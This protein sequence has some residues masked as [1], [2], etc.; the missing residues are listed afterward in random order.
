M[1]LKLLKEQGITD[2]VRK[3]LTDGKAA[4]TPTRALSFD[5]GAWLED[6]GADLPLGNDPYTWE[7]WIRFTGHGPVCGFGGEGDGH[8]NCLYFHDSFNHCALRLQSNTRAIE[9]S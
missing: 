5:G 6:D 3:A 8:A 7:L 4:V 9:P 2:A 1:G